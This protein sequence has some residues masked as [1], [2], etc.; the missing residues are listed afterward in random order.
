MLHEEHY[1]ARLDSCQQI[2]LKITQ[3]HEFLEEVT[4][5]MSQFSTP[6][7]K[8]NGRIR[9]DINFNSTGNTNQTPQN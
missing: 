5:L 2:R 9:E 7:G 1:H 4:F 6:V 8:V 3:S